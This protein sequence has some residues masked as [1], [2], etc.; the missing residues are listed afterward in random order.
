MAAK[1]SSD[2]T[3]RRGNIYDRM[4]DARAR[5]AAALATP[6]AAN[7]ARPARKPQATDAEPQAKREPAPAPS[8]ASDQTTK[9]KPVSPIRWHLIAA[10]VVLITF[11]AALALRDPTPAP[12]AFVTPTTLGTTTT[13]V[14]PTALPSIDASRPT[15]VTAALASAP[16]TPDA[17]G[18]FIAPSPQRITTVQAEPNLA[19]PSIAGDRPRPNPRREDAAV[20]RTAPTKLLLTDL[21]AA[22]VLP[23]AA[24]LDLT[25]AVNVPSNVSRRS[26]AS[27]EERL[28]LLGV[29]APDPKA[30]SFPV[31]KTH[32]RYYHLSDKS[33]AQ[34][35]AEAFDAEAR[36][37]TNFSP[38]PPE[39]FVELWVQ[40]QPPRPVR[41]ERGVF[42]G[43]RRDL[44]QMRS[45]ITGAIR[46]IGR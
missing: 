7:T 9:S 4:E 34:T 13:D 16:T 15:Y 36:D 43:L 5:R 28:A 19:A 20:S 31:T 24:S 25:L 40:G 46:S 29:P 39:G 12:S 35:L 14:A 2:P 45:S 18:F 22:F 17:A 1:T 30:F 42:D 38:S 10:S 3:K 32:V 8:L 26:L 6:V 27:V 21:D 11:A 37:F 23:E 33:K 44:R 41:Q